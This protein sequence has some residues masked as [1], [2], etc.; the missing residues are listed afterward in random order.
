MP[1]RGQFELARIDAWVLTHSLFADLKAGKVSREK[2]VDEMSRLA[3]RA[4]DGDM[5][6]FDHLDSYAQVGDGAALAYLL[7]SA[8]T[9][10]NIKAGQ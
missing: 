2:A 7:N 9:N 1:S 3:K 4:A 10:L 8:V 6:L 5:G